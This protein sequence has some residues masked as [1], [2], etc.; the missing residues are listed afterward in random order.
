[1]RQ[2][3]REAPGHSQGVRQAAGG[4][5]EAELRCRGAAWFDREQ[6]AGGC[7][8]ARES[9]KECDLDAQQLIYRLASKARQ[10]SLSQR[11]ELMKIAAAGLP[12]EPPST[13]NPPEMKS[14]KRSVN[15]ERGPEQRPEAEPEAQQASAKDDAAGLPA[16]EKK[17]KKRKKARK[18]TQA[19]GHS[20]EEDTAVADAEAKVA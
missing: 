2:L 17:P 11:Q 7:Y 20:S 14:K 18:K 5:R 8:P 10:L 1:M 16:P 13:E 19:A 6:A 9:P 15:A 12:E 3:R 4:A